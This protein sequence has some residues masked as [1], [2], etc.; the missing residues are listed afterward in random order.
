MYRQKLAADGI[1]LIAA[2]WRRRCLHL[3]AAP[4]PD[5]PMAAQ[6]IPARKPWANLDKGL[7]L[8]L[9]GSDRGF[10]SNWA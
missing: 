9:R 5:Q 2:R 3:I 8:G 7:G 4:G 10:V 6:I 1:T